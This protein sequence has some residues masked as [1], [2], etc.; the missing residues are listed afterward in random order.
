MAT[1]KKPPMI[2]ELVE[3]PEGLGDAL[4]T[5]AEALGLDRAGAL[6]KIARE[7]LLRVA[8]E[9]YRTHRV[10]NSAGTVSCQRCDVSGRELLA[11]SP[12]L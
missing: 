7:V 8:D 10:V 4:D 3:I 2:M 11:I 6:S 9:G 12:C 1:K 5:Y